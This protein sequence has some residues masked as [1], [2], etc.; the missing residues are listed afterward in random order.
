MSQAKDP[1]PRDAYTPPEEAL[2]GHVTGAGIESKVVAGAPKSVHGELWARSCILCRA[3]LKQPAEPP[4]PEVLSVGQ[5][6]HLMLRDSALGIQRR[7]QFKAKC[8]NSSA[9]SQGHCREHR[10]GQDAHRQVPG[11]FQAT[12]ARPEKGRAGP[13][14]KEGPSSHPGRET[15]DQNLAIC[16]WGVR[17]RKTQQKRHQALVPSIP[18]ESRTASGCFLVVNTQEADSGTAGEDMFA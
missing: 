4:R 3:C 17:K 9:C 18:A 8:S 1:G 12:Q 5:E 11:I 6:D 14:L 16:L 2:G 15:G 10:P 7:F 13:V